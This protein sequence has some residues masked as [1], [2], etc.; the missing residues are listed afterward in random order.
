ME[1]LLKPCPNIRAAISGHNGFAA[2]NDANVNSAGRKIPLIQ[3]NLQYQ[4][5]AG[6]SM[7]LLLRFSADGGMADCTVYH[8]DDRRVVTTPVS[9]YS[10]PVGE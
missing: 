7:V 10:F 1:R 9:G 3:F 2:V 5:N 8:T 4:E 6:D